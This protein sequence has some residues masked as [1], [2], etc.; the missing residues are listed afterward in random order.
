MEKHH[1]ETL[2]AYH[3][4]PERQMKTDG[5][6]PKGQRAAY[7]AAAQCYGEE[8]AKIAHFD[9]SMQSQSRRETV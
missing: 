1:F 7:L 6:A 2:S 8:I 3:G 4:D 5:Y 9:V